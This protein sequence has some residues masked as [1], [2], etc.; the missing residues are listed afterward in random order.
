VYGF[1]F[2]EERWR[3]EAGVCFGFASGEAIMRALAFP[4]G[5]SFVFF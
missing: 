2:F 4:L 5:L 1:E 3:L